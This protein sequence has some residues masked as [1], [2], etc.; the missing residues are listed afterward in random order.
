[1]ATESTLDDKVNGGNMHNRFQ[2]SAHMTLVAAHKT[3]KSMA[4]SYTTY[5][6]IH[7]SQV[8]IGVKPQ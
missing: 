3:A 6:D 7:G 5:C 2:Q 1:M 8:H 4:A